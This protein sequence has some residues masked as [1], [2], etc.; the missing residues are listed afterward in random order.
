ME[1]AASANVAP[2]YRPRTGTAA[3]SAA[4]T[5]ST[6]MSGGERCGRQREQR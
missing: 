5:A 1:S 2:S 4:S 3:K 6:A